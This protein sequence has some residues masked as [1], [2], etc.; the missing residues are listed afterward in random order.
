MV[1][2]T[3]AR[4]AVDLTAATIRSLKDVNPCVNPETDPVY[5]QAMETDEV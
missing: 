2:Y 1:L 4:M 3:Y 5:A